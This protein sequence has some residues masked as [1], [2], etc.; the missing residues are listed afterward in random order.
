MLLWYTIGKTIESNWTFIHLLESSAFKNIYFSLQCPYHCPG[1]NRTCNDL[2]ECVCISGHT[3][4]NC[5][6]QTC[7]EEC[8]AGVCNPKTNLCECTQG[9]HGPSCQQKSDGKLEKANLFQ[10]DT[11]PAE[12]ADYRKLLPR[13]GH[14]MKVDSQGILWVFGGLSKTSPLNDVRAFDTKNASWL[15]ITVHITA[16]IPQERYFQA[17]ELINNQFYIHGGFNG[18]SYF[19]DFWRFDLLR[20]TWN[21]IDTY[22]GLGGKEMKIPLAGHSMTYNPKDQS[23]MIIGGY[24]DLNGFNDQVRIG[25]FI[26]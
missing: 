1:P 10:L 22:R 19:D 18:T 21:Q 26:H 3:G 25:N 7:P 20:K 14:S 15:P 11:L 23:M 4:P 5:D 24:S 8:G 9:Y 13:L 12:S 2:N 17:S 6:Y 16:Q